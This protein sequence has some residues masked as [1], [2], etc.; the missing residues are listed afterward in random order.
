MQVYLA[1]QDTGQVYIDGED[2][3]SRQYVVHQSARV[4]VIMVS[5]PN[6]QEKDR[7]LIL[8]VVHE[9]INREGTQYFDCD[10]V[11][12]FPVNNKPVRIRRY[13]EA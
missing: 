6:T 1:N 2:N 10:E 5:H 3:T 9:G 7:Y 13:S 4:L 8:N 11:V 12:G